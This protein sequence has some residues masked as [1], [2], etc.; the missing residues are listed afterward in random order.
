M[1]T[2]KAIAAYVWEINIKSR[3]EKRIVVQEF[4]DGNVRL[5]RHRRVEAPIVREFSP[6]AA[7]EEFGIGYGATYGGAQ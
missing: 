6:A 3:R 1:F 7:T 5:A 2:P 4:A